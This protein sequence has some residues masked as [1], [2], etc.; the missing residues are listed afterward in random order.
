MKFLLKIICLLLLSVSLAGSAR[1]AKF[2]VSFHNGM[3]D[4]KLG[5]LG[6][7]LSETSVDL[8][9]I[10]DQTTSCSEHE[11]C[12]FIHL[13]TDD[14]HSVPPTALA[15]ESSGSDKT[16]QKYEVKQ[17]SVNGM[18][19]ICRAVRESLR[20]AEYRYS[21][22]NVFVSP[23]SVTQ[24]SRVHFD[25]IK[26]Y[27]E[28]IYTNLLTIIESLVRNS[29]DADHERSKRYLG[30]SVKVPFLLHR[31]SDQGKFRVT[32]IQVDQE[33]LRIDFTVEGEVDDLVYTA[34]VEFLSQEQSADHHYDDTADRIKRISISNNRGTKTLIIARVSKRQQL[35][36]LSVPP[37]PPNS[38]SLTNETELVLFHRNHRM[39]AGEL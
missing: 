27:Q 4:I 25:S 8:T 34:V 2:L 19:R 38:S 16:T 22:G 5:Q 33:Y 24:L 17:P 36:R 30:R 28:E 3:Q 9:F 32:S 6:L 20:P 10:P 18:V 37:P 26:T 12:S 15:I 21:S 23:F 39:G 35:Q 29:P 7:S 13:F 11:I 31:G 14:T 1:A